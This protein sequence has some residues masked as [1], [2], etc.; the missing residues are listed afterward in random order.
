MGSD[1]RERE[2]ETAWDR[3]SVE[4]STRRKL[5]EIC[6]TPSPSAFGEPWVCSV[7]LALTSCLFTACT[8]AAKM[9]L[10]SHADEDYVRILHTTGLGG[11]I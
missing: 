9:H 7:L 6:V 10:G 1:G 8:Q 5:E 3:T 11:D 2:Q 4:S